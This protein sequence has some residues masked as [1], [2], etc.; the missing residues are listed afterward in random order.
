MQDAASFNEVTGVALVDREFNSSRS[1]LSFMYRTG[2]K[3]VWAEEFERVLVNKTIISFW[4][5]ECACEQ[6]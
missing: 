4:P 6:V 2:T 1:P 5:E 3:D